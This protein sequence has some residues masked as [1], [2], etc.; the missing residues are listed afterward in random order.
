MARRSP[1][2]GQGGFL[3]GT[4]LADVTGIAVNPT[5]PLAVDDD[6]PAMDGLPALPGG[7]DRPDGVAGVAGGERRG[8]VAQ[9]AGRHRSVHLRVLR[10]QRVVQGQPE[11]GLL[12][13]AV[14]VP[15]FGRVP[16][17]PRAQPAG[18]AEERRHRHP[19]HDQRRDDRRVPRQRRPRAR[20]AHLQGRDQLQPAARDPGTA[21]R[22]SPLQDQRVRCALANAY[23]SET[24]IATINAGV[25]KLANG[26]FSPEQTG[27]LDDTGYPIQQDMDT[28][29]Q[30]ISE[31]KV[32]HPGP[33]NLSLATPG[34][35][36]PR[37]RPVPEAVVRGG[38]CRLG[39]AGP[40]RPGQLH[41]GRAA[42]ELPGVPVAQP[43]RRGHGPAVHLVALVD[44]AAGG[45]VGPQLRASEGPDPRRGARCQPGETDPAKKQ[46]Y[47]EA[48]NQRFADQC[49]NIWFGWTTWAILHEPTVHIEPTFTTPEGVESAPTSEI[50]NLRTAWVDQ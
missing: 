4:A 42:R 41:R 6:V 13:P 5:D 14:P 35:D 11:P 9:V 18:R 8:R 10:A 25:D 48:V 49:F 20:G 50:A 17:D 19:P 3:T 30:L 16:S 45:P 15:R 29:K 28:A 44:R 24:V 12:E 33:L 37:H 32:E 39:D 36:Q 46:G 23:D 40:D 21:G 2:P 43:Q 34:R 22:L 38:R 1:H 26:P 27:Y 31:Y 7:P 47:A